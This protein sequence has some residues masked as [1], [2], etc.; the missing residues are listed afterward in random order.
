MQ[1]FHAAKQCSCNDILGE[2]VQ[3]QN[4]RVTKILDVSFYQATVS[5]FDL[6]II[7]SLWIYEGFMNINL[8]NINNIF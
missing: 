3:Q 6:H 2:G 5:A 7:Q 8:T 1:S 4:R